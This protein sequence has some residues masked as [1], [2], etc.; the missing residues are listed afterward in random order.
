M[1]PQFIPQ[2]IT[3]DNESSLLKYQLS[4]DETLEK[5]RLMLLNINYNPETEQFEPGE[6]KIYDRKHVE[7]M[8]HILKSFINKETILSGFT[9][10]NIY[11][12]VFEAGCS[13]LDYMV[14]ISVESGVDDVETMNQMMQDPFYE[15]HGMKRGGYQ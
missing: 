12:L 11:D 14:G 1:E 13:I 8:M 3:N 4:V 6:E 15:N 5:I 7:K 10:K 9:D 2:Y